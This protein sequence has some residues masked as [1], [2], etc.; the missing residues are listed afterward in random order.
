MIKRLTN[1]T[2]GFALS[3]LLRSGSTPDSKDYFSIAAIIFSKMASSSAAS[4]SSS[5]WW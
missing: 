3:T 2:M 1:P 5:G 4:R